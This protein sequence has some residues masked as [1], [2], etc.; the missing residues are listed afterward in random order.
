LA[1]VST[2]TSCRSGNGS[3]QSAAAGQSQKKT[4]PNA[5]VATSSEKEAGTGDVDPKNALLLMANKI[6]SARADRDCKTVA[7]YLD[8]N[9]YVAETPDERLGI[10]E[11]D[12]FRYEKYRIGQVDVE[13]QYGWVHVEYEAKLAPYKDEPAQEVQAVEKWRL[14]NRQWY[15]V[16][17]RIYET[18][19]ESPSVRNAAEEKRL[20]ERFEATWKL[21]LARDWKSLYEMTDPAD[22]ERVTESAYAD[23]EG[24]I[25]YY[26]HELEWVQVIGD[27]GEVRV[28]YANKL[29]DPNMAKLSPRK[30][31]LSEHWI[32]RNGGWYRDL[33][34]TK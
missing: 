14:T 2:V 25:T 21:R 17:A 10:C 30:I 32:N 34:R 6:W 19:P 23:S 33:V 15:P 8:P 20:G 7:Q 1:L 3:A 26:E 31:N 4:N 28:T 12:P 27:V 24:L 13:G 9:E 22:R 29:A 16:A 18:C 11:K 5:V